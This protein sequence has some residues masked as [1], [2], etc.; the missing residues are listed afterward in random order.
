MEKSEKH[1]YWASVIAKWQASNQSGKQWCEEQKIVYP[2]FC[3]WKAKLVHS[4]RTGSISFEELKEDRSSTVLMMQWKEVSISIPEDI[5]IST[6]ERL[7]IA[8]GRA[9]C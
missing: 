9:Q 6:L 3:Y 5:E 1:E 8:L 7:F 4:D 2:T